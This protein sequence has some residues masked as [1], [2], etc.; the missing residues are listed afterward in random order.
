VVL[1]VVKI[2]FMFMFIYCL[3]I[4]ML[5]ALS[6]FVN[7]VFVICLVNHVLGGNCWFSSFIY[8]AGAGHEGWSW[9]N[10]FTKINVSFFIVMYDFYVLYL[11]SFYLIRS[12]NCVDFVFHFI[13]LIK[14]TKY[15]PS[16]FLII[17]G[18]GG[19][20]YLLIRLSFENYNRL[21]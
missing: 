4:I 11:Y 6:V 17:V 8:S 5:H 14:L 2:E 3:W 12:L 19:G 20:T 1:A 21:M 16:L 13:L 15:E 9:W 10:S 7:C 18:C